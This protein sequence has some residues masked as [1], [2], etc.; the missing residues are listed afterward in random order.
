MYFIVTIVSFGYGEEGK[1]FDWK[2][3]NRGSNSVKWVKYEISRWAV[4]R[5]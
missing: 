1:F 3:R 2:M 4:C 5:M